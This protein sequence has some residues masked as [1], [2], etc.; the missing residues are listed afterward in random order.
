MSFKSFAGFLSSFHTEGGKGGL[1]A[2][3]IFILFC[4]LALPFLADG[5]LIEKQALLKEAV[6]TA[7]DASKT[8]RER[9]SAAALLSE[10]DDPNVLEIL[11]VTIR[12]TSEKPL[13][14]AVM[15]QG[16]SKSPQKSVVAAFLAGRLEDSKEATEVRSAAA[17][18]LGNIGLPVSKESLGRSSSD[19]NPQVRQAAR[20]ALLSLEGNDI[21]RAGL[22]IAGLQ[23]KEQKAA[24]RAGAARQLGELKDIRALQPLILA[25]HEKSPDIPSPQSLKDF[26]IVRS[27]IKEHIPAA[28]ATALGQLGSKDAVSPLLSLTDTPDNEFR[29]AIFEALAKLKSPDAV[30]AAR[31]AVLYDMDQ[32][33]RRWAG[34]ILKYAADK[35]TLPVLLKA[36]KDADP[37][38]RLQA[39][40]AIGNIKEPRAKKELEEAFAREEN[41][42]VREAMK[43][44]VQVLKELKTPS[45]ADV[46]N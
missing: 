30:P 16:L 10:S 12:N 43:N 7:A 41:R 44:A 22:L 38:V 27:L 4:F 35:D 17:R 31:K 32:R 39:A 8:D 1:H 26:F 5:Q 13:L 11:F 3:F 19:I 29:T 42:E 21:D 24:V 9:T 25:L 15:V 33:V 28:A 37:G 34:V 20:D 36:L 2:A 45:E 6:K 46:I 40:Q 23:D 14:R 18:A